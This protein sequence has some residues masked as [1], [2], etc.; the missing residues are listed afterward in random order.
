MKTEF[1]EE[2]QSQ[3]QKVDQRLDLRFLQGKAELAQDSINERESER[4]AQILS[5][6]E[7]LL[8][9]SVTILATSSPEG[10]DKI[11]RD[12]AQ[13]RAVAARQYVAR[14]LRGV[15]PKTETK[16]YTW[17]D[18]ADRLAAEGK[19]VE[20]Q[21]VRDAIAAN[22]GNKV[23]LDRALRQQAFYDSII[24]PVLSSMR[25]MSYT[26]MFE[27]HHVLTE[28]EVVQSYYKNKQDYLSVKWN[29]RAETITIFIG[30]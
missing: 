24:G 8:K 21:T 6:Q 10:S 19:R 4:M 3:F 18:V 12:L 14:Y 27:K 2:A 29:S 30:I 20:A 13:K 1:Y 9:S 28:T 5:D 17:D 11:N 26:Y 23:A 7:G 25:V 15:S 16:I 22:S